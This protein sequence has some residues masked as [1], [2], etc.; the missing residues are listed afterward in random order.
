M[1]KLL[2]SILFLAAAL[3]A[4]AQ[5]ARQ[6]TVET[7]VADVLAAM[8]ANNAADF[9]A[10]IADLA[11]AAPASVL[12]TAKMMKPAAKGVRNNL[13]EYALNGLASYASANPQCADKVR[14]GF[15]Q[16]IKVTADSDNKAFLLNLLRQIAKPADASLF[17]EYV[18]DPALASTAVGALVDIP[19]TE[20]LILGLVKEGTA[21]RALLA[22]AA[23]EKGISAA[24]PYILKWITTASGDSAKSDNALFSALAKIGSE[25]SLNILK[26]NST[27]D[28]ASLAVRLADGSRNKAVAK[29]AK[30]L[31]ASPVSAY[32]SAG[33]LAGMKNDPAKALK[34]VAS[35]LKSDDI[36]Y[37]N[38]VIGNATSILGAGNLVPLFTK[39]FAKQ[40]E[41]VKVDLLNWFGNNKI[42]SV[43]DIV[44]GSFSEGGDVA[45]AAIAAAGK[46]GGDKAAKALVGQLGGENGEAALAALKSFKG[47][48]QDELLA[49]LDNAKDEKALANIL[50]LVAERGISAAAPKVYSLIDSDDETTAGIATIA[51]GGIVGV[52]DIDKVGALLDKAKDDVDVTVLSEALISAV[53]TLAP[54]DQYAKVSAL[55]KKSGNAAAYYRALA[56][57]GTDE[58]VNDL[59][60]AYESGNKSAF[61]SLLDIDNFKAAPVLVKIAGSDASLADQAVKRYASLVSR[62]E[63]NVDKKRMDFAKALELAKS[64]AV[65]RTI[66]RSLSSV[67]TMKSFLLAGKYLDDSDKNVRHAAAECVRTIASKTT[68]EINYADLKSNLDKAVAIFK[69]AGGADDGYA[70][71]EIGKILG[72][73][74]PSPVSQLTEE[75]KRQ[76]FEMLFDG[77]NLDKWHG[78]LEGYTPVNGTIYV[79]ANYGS[80]GNLYTKK[81]YRNFVYRFEFCF[82]REGVNNG[83]GVRTPMGVDAAYDAMCEVQILDHDAPMYANLREYQVH[84][85]VYGVIPAKRI[86]HKPLGEWN[87][88]EIRVEGD[89]IKV[90]LNGEVI[91]DG[92]VRKACKGHNVAPDGSKKNPYTVDHKNHPGMFNRKGYISF[93]GHGEGL[94]I[95]NVRILDLGDKK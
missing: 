82:L 53:H 21:D 15:S 90:I 60:S 7:V 79:S 91:L 16:A 8:P 11:A 44:I 35:V 13:Y 58:A 18:S 32:K 29:A 40:S 12:E 62:Y 87:T 19:G 49:A 47:N 95:R 59:A 83:V 2:F 20:D 70:V 71:D 85:S 80:T 65:K 86:V 42:G 54:A 28:F 10:Q 48:Y 50:S 9:N 36:K 45:S 63:T 89:N 26:D 5:D 64:P 66:L 39:N 93:C 14:E 77:T 34:V 22:A 88:E 37:R 24:E 55:M 30:E 84:G 27:P 72:E 23:A 67:P 76:G 57:T 1:K 68:E 73:A 92:N 17:K 78:D 31:M 38:S 3:T 6:R 52:R 61:A 56:S 41:N 69:A 74:E 94:K 33:A 43:S 46:I 4:N 75:E 81:E 25:E 51:L